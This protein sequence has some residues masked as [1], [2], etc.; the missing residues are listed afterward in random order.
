[1]AMI[2]AALGGLAG[3]L[4]LFFVGFLFWGTPLAELAVHHVDAARTASL[5]ASLAETLTESG[6]GTYNIPNPMTSEGTVLYGKGPIAMVHYNVSG[7]PVA[8]SK[9]LFLGLAMALTT[10]LLIAGALWGVADRVTSF[11]DRAKLVVLL[12]LAATF[13]TELGQPVFNHFGWGYFVYLFLSN[14][15]GLSVAGLVIARW[16]LPKPL[17]NPAG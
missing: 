6:T 16:F 1:M 14:F 8:D 3:G 17:I 7:F 5:Q 2:K 4:A 13:Y 12:A 9:A 11:A 10:G 15:V